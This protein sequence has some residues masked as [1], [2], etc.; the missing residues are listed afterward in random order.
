MNVNSGMLPVGPILW[1][2]IGPYKRVLNIVE[3]P[4][5]GLLAA[6]PE[7]C[8]LIDLALEKMLQVTL[9]RGS[10]RV[11][12]YCTT[13]GRNL[14]LGVADEGPWYEDDDQL[15]FA[16]VIDRVQKLSG[17]FNLGK[18]ESEA[19]TAVELRVPLSN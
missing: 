12:V 17:D 9:D 8:E 7:V 13:S 14:V 2:H 19:E 4:S 10:E 18:L 11:R 6:P 3:N 5:V 15:A 1:K 16:E